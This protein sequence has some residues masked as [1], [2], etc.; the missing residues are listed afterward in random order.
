[1]LLGYCYIVREVLYAPI[2]VGVK[3]AQGVWGLMQK[4][5]VSIALRAW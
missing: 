4:R 2:W 1:M 3:R 5:G